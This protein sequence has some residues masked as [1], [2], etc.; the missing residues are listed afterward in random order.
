MVFGI[1]CLEFEVLKVAD[2]SL[3]RFPAD[4][5]SQCSITPNGMPIT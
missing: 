2:W 3:G 4:L 5:P 1:W